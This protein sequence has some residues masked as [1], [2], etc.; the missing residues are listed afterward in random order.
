MVLLK[1][2]VLRYAVY[3]RDALSDQDQEKASSEGTRLYEAVC[4]LTSSVVDSVHSTNP[5]LGVKLERRGEGV[6]VWRPAPDAADSPAGIDVL[7]VRKV[8]TTH[9][10]NNIRQAAYKEENFERGGEGVPI[11][12]AFLTSNAG[13][14][15]SAKVEVIP[16]PSRGALL[17][18]LRS[19]SLIGRSGG[20]G[21][22][23]VAAPV[24][25]WVSQLTREVASLLE[26]GPG[27]GGESPP[28]EVVF[29]P[30]VQR[31]PCIDR[32]FSG[33]VR[34]AAGVG[35]VGCVAIP[36][37]VLDPES[38][39]GSTWEV[40]PV[41]VPSGLLLSARVGAG[42]HRVAPFSTAMP[43]SGLVDEVC[44]LVSLR[45]KYGS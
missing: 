22:G 24:P 6:A 10:E 41:V 18:Q 15:G 7:S 26:A 23:C 13:G 33:S 38:P 21:S 37:V 30:F 42:Q 19:W 11:H 28:C 39:A 2:P 43:L 8:T 16:F 17:N 25:S 44:Y 9:S 31:H 29:V 35:E 34:T 40:T 20:G 5:S 27:S 4:R 3:Y 45:P 14:L 36:S 32:S 12:W 1:A